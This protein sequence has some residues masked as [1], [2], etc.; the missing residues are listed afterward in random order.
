[1]FR[2]GSGAPFTT[3]QYFTIHHSTCC[4]GL[5]LLSMPSNIL[6][7][8]AGPFTAL[9]SQITCQA[10]ASLPLF[11]CFNA[12]CTIC[13]TTLRSRSSCSRSLSRFVRPP[14][15][16]VA[17]ACRSEA[18][19]GLRFRAIKLRMVSSATPCFIPNR[20]P[21]KHSTTTYRTFG[22]RASNS[23]PISPST[24]FTTA[25]SA[26]PLPSNP[27]SPATAK[28]PRTRSTCLGPPW[29]AAS[30]RN[31]STRW[32]S[33]PPDPVPA[34]PPPPR[35]GGSKP[36]RAGGSKRSPWRYSRWCAAVQS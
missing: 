31:T 23:A 33:R 32:T 26:G 17:T 1:M 19:W 20:R 30:C 13:S 8:R 18:L 15:L 2:G 12:S 4:R 24:S 29:A 14:A 28:L 3:K 34:D 27:F 36:P 7:S 16:A 5:R 35:A 21:S 6:D 10:K 9:Y 25:L 11:T 22:P